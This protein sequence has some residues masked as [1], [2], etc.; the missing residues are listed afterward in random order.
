MKRL[1]TFLF[2]LMA[3]LFLAGLWHLFCLRFESG[4]VYP[5]YSTFRADPLGA[6]ALY[7]SLARVLEARRHVQPH[8]DASEGRGA[9]LFL[10]GAEG[11]G[12][13]YLPGDFEELERFA[14]AGGRLVVSLQPQFE[15]PWSVM[16]ERLSGAVP[17]NRPPAKSGKKSS[18][19]APRRSR[20][21]EELP[22]EMRPVS[23]AER[24]KFEVKRGLA[25]RDEKGVYQ[26]T[27]AVRKA[28]LPL[29][30]SIE[31]H[32][33]VWFDKPDPAWRVIYAREKDRPLVM[34]RSLGAG[35]LVLLSDSYYF[36]NQALRSR[37]QPELLAWLVGP[38]HTVVFD[39]THLGV[40]ESTGL[41]TLARKY[42]LEGLFLALLVLAGLFLWKEAVRFLPP[43]GRPENVDEPVLGRD[44]AAGFVNL[45]R[46]NLRAA[47]AL[48]TCFD[49]W[50]KS[51][52]RHV[53]AGKLRQLDDIVRAEQARSSK[54]RDPVRA[55]RQCCEVMDRRGME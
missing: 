47:D 32:T 34:E 12:E 42:R 40:E 6:K 24:W 46:R 2:A 44:S 52:A 51:C 26:P 49:E 11:A 28:D 37:R 38:N 41:A 43:P 15:V 18:R 4:D 8:L 55:Y 5:A 35:T 33:A 20:N 31:W 23:M 50:K 21:N 29:P 3:A 45:L 48:G 39:E 17:T 27:L 36:S 10:L 16:A 19:P 54:H 22:P 14:A 9:T 30:P 7:E 25:Q 1:P 13:R 53:P